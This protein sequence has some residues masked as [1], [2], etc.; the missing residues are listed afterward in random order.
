MGQLELEGGRGVLREGGVAVSKKVETR[1]K[2]C[3][4][5][6]DKKSM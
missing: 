6:T 5:Q 4:A 2:S 1:V 3:N